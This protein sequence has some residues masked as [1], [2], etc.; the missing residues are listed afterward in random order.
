M[1]LPIGDYGRQNILFGQKDKD[2]QDKSAYRY[3]TLLDNNLV[4]R[5]RIGLEKTN[6]SFTIYPARGLKG[7]RNANF[8][9][10]LSMGVVPYLIGSAT[11]IAVFNCKPFQHFDKSK[12]AKLGRPM[13]LGVVLYGVFKELSKALITYP[14][15]WK[16]G[17]DT[18]LPYAKVNY[19]FDE[20]HE[21]QENNNDITSTEY[22]K[23]G[24]SVDFPRWDLL[25]G[26]PAKGEKLNFRY[27]KIAKKNG[28]GEDL[29]DSDQEVK[30]IYKEVLVKSKLAKSISSFLWGAV[31]VALAFQSPMENYFKAATLKIWKPAKFFGQFRVFG[32]S[33][34]AGLKE[35]YNGAPNAETKIEKH[36]G[37]ALLGLAALSTVLG[38]LN[39]I[40]IT[41]KPKPVNVID[42]T[43][44]S[45]A[46]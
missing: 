36:A 39:T 43:K 30:P 40:H 23:I 33:F 41:K 38:L 17:I 24:E 35:L 34:A 9:E 42:N 28:L 26:D 22:H 31:G 29:N 3:D 44:E 45:A 19:L 8:Y 18:E 27:D 11:L 1:I 2:N 7:S 6:K 25:Y 5:T 12:A 32:S 21:S 10:F 13:A 14:V 46:S 4:T 37:K 20:L 15:K 16:T